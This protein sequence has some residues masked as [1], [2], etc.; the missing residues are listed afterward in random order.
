MKK[1]EG[2]VDRGVR[3]VVGLVL[4]SLTVVGPKTPWGYVGLVPLV[5]GAIAFCPLYGLLRLKTTAAEQK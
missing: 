2:A 3:V 1:N 5:T 4:L